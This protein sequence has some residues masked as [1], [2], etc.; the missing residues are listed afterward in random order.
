MSRYHSDYTPRTLCCV[1]G[2]VHQ[3]NLVFSTERA[4]GDGLPLETSAFKLCSGQFMLSTQL[5]TIITHKM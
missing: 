3:G 1:G 4:I 2:R 5:M